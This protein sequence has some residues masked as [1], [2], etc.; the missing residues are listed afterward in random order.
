MKILFLGGDSRFIYACKYLI[1]KGYKASIISDFTNKDAKI[2]EYNNLINESGIIV[3]PSP[4][5]IDNIHIKGTIA[6]NTQIKL[7][8]IEKLKDKKYIL[9]PDNIYGNIKY[10]D[11]DYLYENAYLTAEGTL[12]HLLTDYKYKL[13]DKRITI[14][15]YG[16]ISVHL[17]NL[18][19]NFTNN[20]TVVLRDK[21]KAKALDDR[22]IK[23]SNFERLK[24][25]IKNTDILI[26]TVPALVV[27]DKVLSYADEGIYIID[28]ASK[29]GG[30][31]F[32][33]AKSNNIDCVHLLG[34][35]GKCAPASDG[36]KIGERI[37][38]IIYNL[39]LK[40]ERI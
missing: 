36:E 13:K 8:E 27:D 20:I 28:L 4:L 2:S 33:F 1:S 23:T 3:L 29:P 11:E 30:I 26:N 14:L 9:S 21:V 6:E 31:N 37:Y 5:T 32:D 22:K 40:G 38:K 16:R 7:A 15:G 18:L 34:I 25:V 19:N 24:E 35:P 12:G 10:T 39:E 17:L